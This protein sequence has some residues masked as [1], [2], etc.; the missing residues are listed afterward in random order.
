M[1]AYPFSSFPEI[2]RRARGRTLLLWGSGEIAAK[3]IRRLPVPPAGFVDNDPNLSGTTYLD[4]PVHS[5]GYL[6]G[7]PVAEFFFV[8][9]TTSFTEVAP[10]LQALGFEGERDFVISPI[11][12]DLRIIAEMEACEVRLLFSSGAPA[13]DNPAYGGGIYELDLKG[14]DCSVRKV[15]S[16]TCHGLLA[17]DRQ[18]FAVDHR[19]GILQLDQDYAVQRVGA[20]P[21]ASRAHGI[22]FSEATQSFYVVASYMD[23][24]LIYDRDLTPN[25]EIPLSDKCQL[26][27]TSCHHC[28]DICSAGASLFVSMFSH[29]GN[30]KRDIYD[31]VVLEL[32]A[33]TGAVRHPVI[34]DLWMPHN[35]LMLGGSLTVLD[36]LRGGLRRNNAQPV[37]EFP[38][39]S[40][41]LAY[42]GHFFYIGQSR[43]RNYSKVLGI[44]NNISIDASII[45]FDEETKVSRSLPLPSKLS[46]IHAIL[47]LDNA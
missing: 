41:G 2:S 22:A 35:P 46:E 24:V 38:G 25:G 43:N 33:A 34:R 12:N 10:Q 5:P 44:S 42:D 29:T 1:R 13:T 26:E 17:R 20:L 23:K 39:F 11:L 32:D 45:I 40:R 4:L 14:D 18:I 19:Q 8:V 15:Y 16:G 9:C 3:T 37:G 6:S 47:V 31:G 28:N 21:P 7:K 30:W 36:S 27:G